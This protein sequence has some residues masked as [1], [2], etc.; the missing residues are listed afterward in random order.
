MKKA[1]VVF[2]EFEY[3]D[4]LKLISKIRGAFKVEFIYTLLPPYIIDHAIHQILR[5]RRINQFVA[6]VYEHQNKQSI[7]TSGRVC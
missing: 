6:L 3:K 2:L 7:E 1:L 5:R 4:Q